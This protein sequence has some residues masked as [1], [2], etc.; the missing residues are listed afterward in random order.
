MRPGGSGEL[1]WVGPDPEN[2]WP[3]EESSGRENSLKSW[4]QKAHTST[5]D[6]VASRKLLCKGQSGSG[7][8]GLGR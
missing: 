2:R 3:S 6:G 5:G 8:S 7:Q 1:V 4:E